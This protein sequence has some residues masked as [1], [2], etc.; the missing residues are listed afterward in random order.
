MRGVLLKSCDFV[1]HAR[2]SASRQEISSEG[3]AHI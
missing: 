2:L 3:G 1:A